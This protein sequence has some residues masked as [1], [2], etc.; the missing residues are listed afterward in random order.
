MY[1]YIYYTNTHTHVYIYYIYIYTIIH[2]HI[3]LSICSDLAQICVYIYIYV[4]VVRNLVWCDV[5]WSKLMWCAGVMWRSVGVICAC[6]IVQWMYVLFFVLIF[7]AMLL[8]CNVNVK[9]PLL[10]SFSVLHVTQCYAHVKLVTIQFSN[11][12]PCWTRQEWGFPWQVHCGAYV[13]FFAMLAIL[14]CQLEVDRVN[15]ERTA[16]EAE[17]LRKGYQGDDLMSHPYNQW[18]VF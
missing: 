12:S 10:L 18:F 1:I 9:C 7:N 13:A 8:A 11:A 5:G 15:A 16:L 3:F 4:S 14:F 17:Q 6:A 2:N